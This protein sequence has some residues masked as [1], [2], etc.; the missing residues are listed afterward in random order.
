MGFFS[1]LFGQKQF[2][3][4]AVAASSFPKALRE[5]AS[6]QYDKCLEFGKT[7]GWSEDACIESTNIATLSWLTDA[8]G[9]SKNVS[10]EELATILRWEGL[11]FNKL[12]NDIAK[13]ALIEYVVWRQYPDKAD[14]KLVMAAMSHLV[15]RLKQTGGEGDELLQGFR[16]SPD[17]AWLPWRKLIS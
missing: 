1:S 9:A 2:D 8:I 5:L 14:M 13:T 16:G 11:P 15:S 4:N 10:N 7:K 17:F 6:A 12:P 3:A